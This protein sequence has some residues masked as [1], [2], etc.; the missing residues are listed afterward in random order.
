ML[1]ADLL[2]LAATLLQIGTQVA[3]DG[4]TE[5]NEDELK[6]INDQIGRETGLEG[7]WTSGR[8]T[9]SLP[10]AGLEQARTHPAI[11]PDPEGQKEQRN[12]LNR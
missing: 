12:R 1:L 3:A 8:K 4:R 9:Q 7:Q 11:V 10:Q 6:V 5:T 2:A